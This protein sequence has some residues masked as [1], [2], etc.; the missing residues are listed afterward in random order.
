M[1]INWQKLELDIKNYLENGKKDDTGKNYSIKETAKMIEF[2]YLTEIKV[3]ATDIF[4]NKV[5]LITENEGTGLHKSLETGFNSSF[6][7]GKNTLLNQNGTSGVLQHWAGAQFY[8]II[9]ALPA[10]TVGINN[11]VTS[12]G[13]IISMN[14]I[15]YSDTNDLFAKEVVKSLKAHAGTIGGLF[16]GFTSSGSPIAVPWLGIY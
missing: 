10:M 16:T 15:G 3:N 5:L 4:L 11:I 7:T 13:S 14:L 8:P 1:A 9:P 6:N 2:L 12:T